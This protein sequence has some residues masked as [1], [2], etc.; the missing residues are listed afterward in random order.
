[1]TETKRWKALRDAAVSA[2]HNLAY[3]EERLEQTRYEAGDS[4]H[5][6][7][8]DEISCAEAV[9]R[10]A[11][12]L[13]ALALWELRKEGRKAGSTQTGEARVYGMVK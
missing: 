5:P 11:R 6:C 7:A 13:R 9:V 3:C 10:S 1:M 2:S 4:K 8:L 12:T